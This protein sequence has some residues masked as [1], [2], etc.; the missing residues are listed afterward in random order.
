MHDSRLRFQHSMGG[1]MKAIIQEAQGKSMQLHSDMERSKAI[2]E[3]AVAK[4]REEQGGID[5]LVVRQNTMK[6]ESDAL[7]ARLEE[8]F[9]N[10][11][12]L[13]HT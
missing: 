5:V 7:I 13:R 3:G 4:L 11:R 2:H 10:S 1:R 9:A 8:D 12:R 6:A